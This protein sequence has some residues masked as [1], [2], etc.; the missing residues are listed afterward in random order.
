MTPTQLAVI[1]CCPFLEFLHE[2]V[3]QHGATHFS[4][5]ICLGFMFHGMMI[6]SCNTSPDSY[7]SNKT[8][9]RYRK[10]Y[11]TDIQQ[12]SGH[13]SHTW[14]PS[15]APNTAVQGAQEVVHTFCSKFGFVRVH[16]ILSLHDDLMRLRSHEVE[17][18]RGYS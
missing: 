3:N 14:T 9:G 10:H 6:M 8:P 12:H 11:P 15:L 16:S 13:I 17:S 4:K 5:E 7:F 18:A 1:W 2:F